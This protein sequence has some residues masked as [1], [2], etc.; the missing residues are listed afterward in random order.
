MPGPFVPFFPSDPDLPAEVDAVVIGGGIIGCSTAL[1]LAERGLRVALCEKGSIGRE[2]SSRNWG[3][4]RLSFRDPREVPLMAASL[5]LWQ[6]LAERLGEDVGYRRSGIVFNCAGDRDAERNAR[7]LRHVA[8]LGIGTEMIPAAEV[9]RRFPGTLASS[10]A[11]WS[12]SDGR[13]EPQLVT[14]ALARA[15]RRAGVHV[16]TECAVRSLDLSAGAVSGV[17]TEHGPIRARAV[18]L[19]GGVWS[20]VFTDNLGLRFP[21]LP[22]MNSLLRTAPLAGGPEAALDTDTFAFR[23]REDGGYTVASS[24]RDIADIVPR[25][26]RYLRQFLPA[27]R[28]QWS[29]LHLRFGARFVEEW[30]VGRR[31]S[32]DDPSPFEYRRVMDPVPDRKQLDR[33]FARLQATLPAF[34]QARVT[35]RWGG[36]LD[37]TPD[38]IPVISAMDGIPGFFMASGFSGHGFGIGPGAGRLM[39]DL[40]L[41]DTPVV[42]PSEFRFSRFADGSRL[43]IL[44]GCETEG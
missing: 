4:V 31:W 10:G 7:W 43:R 14:P 11:L 20:T 6:G 39:A 44:T 12:P 17:V 18:V 22:V 30:Q 8:D 23:K 42:D 27:L 37:T 1:E 32:P 33:I 19:A 3:W 25:S 38:A 26:F 9:Q 36:V 24:T 13:A 34:R 28:H 35:Q 21:Q 40:V 5:D 41:N 15:A 29:G 16:L 2:Q